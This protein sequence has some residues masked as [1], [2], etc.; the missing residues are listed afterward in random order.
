[1]WPMRNG[2]NKWDGVPDESRDIIGYCQ[3]HTEDERRK[4][5]YLTSDI[6]V[7]CK[8][9]MNDINSPIM[10]LFLIYK[11]LFSGYPSNTRRIYF[12]KTPPGVQLGNFLSKSR[13]DTL[14][15]FTHEV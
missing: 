6:H 15:V 2:T 12:F 7:E 3:L 11:M 8:K 1:M 10:S 13:V 9:R 14:F 4:Q 5:S